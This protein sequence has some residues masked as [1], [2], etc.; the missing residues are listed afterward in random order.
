MLLKHTLSEFVQWLACDKC[1][2]QCKTKDD[3]HKHVKLHHSDVMIEEDSGLLKCDFKVKQ[4]YRM[5]DHKLIKHTSDEEALWLQC[6]YKKKLKVSLERPIMTLHKSDE[7]AKWIYCLNC[8]Y[9]TQRKENLRRH[10]YLKHTTPEAVQWFACDK[11]HFQTKTKYDLEQP[12]KT[13]PFGRKDRR[14]H[15]MVEM[16]QM[17]LQGTAKVPTAATRTGQTHAERRR[18]VV[19]M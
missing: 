4:K 7:E 5:K 13:A 2:Y 10:M 8:D 12:R 15:R 1:E 17:R 11:C 19:S 6:S 3:L 9:R 14:E 18:G 16:R